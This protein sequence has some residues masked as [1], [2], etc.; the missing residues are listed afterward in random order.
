MSSGC[1]GKIHRLHSI[2]CLPGNCQAPVV[3]GTFRALFIAQENPDSILYNSRNFENFFPDTYH[4]TQNCECDMEVTYTAQ[5]M[6]EVN[7]L[8]CSVCILCSPLR[9]HGQYSLQMAAA[10][11]EIHGSDQELVLLSDPAALGGT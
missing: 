6:R 9:S 5:S 10:S 1:A 3:A 7:F 2:P 8:N 11:G 4:L